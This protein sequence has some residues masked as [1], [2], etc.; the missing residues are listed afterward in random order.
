MSA[1]FSPDVQ[2]F[3]HWVF[4]FKPRTTHECAHRMLM[5]TLVPP[6]VRNNPTEGVTVYPTNRPNRATDICTS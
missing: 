4:D 5:Q 1:G 2:E 3:T 6:L